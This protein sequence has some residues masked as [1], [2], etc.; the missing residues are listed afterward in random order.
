[1]D[2]LAVYT[3]EDAGTALQHERRANLFLQGR[4]LPDMYRFG[5]TSVMWDAVEKSA[6]GAFFPIPIREC[7]A[8]DNVSC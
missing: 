4:R 1:M 2:G 3:T 8:N 6:A 5:A 7:R